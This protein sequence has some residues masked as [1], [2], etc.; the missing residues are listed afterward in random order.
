ML[1][2]MDTAINALYKVALSSSNLSLYI[3]LN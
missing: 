2:N 1:A 3:K